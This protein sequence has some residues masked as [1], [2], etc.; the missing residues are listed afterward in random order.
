MSDLEGNKHYPLVVIGCGA[1]GSAV[2]YY[3]S[4]A[5]IKSLAIEQFALGHNKG[6]SS[7]QTRIFRSIYAE[8]PSYHPLLNDALALWQ[9]LEKKCG[10]RLFYNN[11][12]LAI[13]NQGSKWLRQL[14]MAA[15]KHTASIDCLTSNDIMRMYPSLNLKNSMRGILQYQSGVLDLDECLKAYVQQAQKLGADF[16]SNTRVTGLSTKDNKVIVKVEDAEYSADHV[17]ITAGAWLNFF[18]LERVEKVNNTAKLHLWFGTSPGYYDLSDECT[19]FSFDLDSDFFYGIPAINGRIKVG[20]HTGGAPISS[21]DDYKD[22]CLQ[23]ERKAIEEFFQTYWHSS[24]VDVGCDSSPCIYSQTRSE[25]FIIT[26]PTSNISV[27]AGLAGHGFKMS[28]ALA[29]N[30]VSSIKDSCF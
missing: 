1:A 19:C 6:G 10:K 28:N 22:I 12:V 24:K 23:E 27:L 16:L 17:V 21:L 11:G 25:R 30:L 7:G 18:N 15:K 29:K 13:G 3:A 2:T 9:D 14:E 8:D 20:R 5:G 4:C 26:N